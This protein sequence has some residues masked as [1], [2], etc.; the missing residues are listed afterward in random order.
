MGRV[1][2]QVT[3]GD[4]LIDR[5]SV[6]AVWVVMNIAAVGHSAVGSPHDAQITAVRFNDFRF[7]CASATDACGP[8]LL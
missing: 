4:L 8:L 2:S 1:A 7:S 3:A 6:R 5:F